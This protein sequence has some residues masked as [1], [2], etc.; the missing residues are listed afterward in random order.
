MDFESPEVMK[1]FP[2]LYVSDANKKGNNDSDYSDDV[3]KVTKK[4]LLIGK[5]KDKK[6]KKD[7]ERGYAALE[8][9]SSPDESCD[10]KSPSKSKKS[11][12]FKFSS[13]SK[14]KREKS[15]DKDVIEKKKDKDKKSEKKTDKDKKTE[16]KERKMKHGDEFPDIADK[17]PIF[18]VPLDIA[19]ER[20]RCH[21]GI[22]IPYPVRACVNYLQAF[23]Y[24]FE[25]V[26][27]I[28]GSKSKAIQIK[29]MFNNREA[30]NL[31]EYDVPTVTSL[32][33][34]YLREMPD[35]V[36]TNELLIRFEEAG[37]ILNIG[38]REKH[39]KIL[40]EN[41]PLH[42]KLLLSW[43]LLHFDYIICNERLNKTSLQNLV[44]TMSPVLRMTTRLLTALLYHCHVLF[45]DTIIKP[46]VPPITSSSELPF[47]SELIEEELKKQESL[48]SQIHMEI[49]SGF[50]SKSREELMWE[51][52]R[53]IT[54]LKVIIQNNGL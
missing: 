44:T 43:L 14:E 25:G 26:Y 8:G 31:N 53:M 30:V 49:H 47:D 32:L 52:Q 12:P 50:I 28:S 29:K 5:R 41:L 40:V 10:A 37:A 35:S 11:K 48:L 38:T 2:G 3:D 20:S 15:R 54:Q 22:D 45:P 16:K 9:E 51:V 1:D 27:K 17:L 36:L 42:N 4:E 24:N 6:D 19:I 34:L 13:K 39:L 7:K 21:D 33:K 18:G 46:Y 23:G